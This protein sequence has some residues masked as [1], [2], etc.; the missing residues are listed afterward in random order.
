MN[1]RDVR[2]ESRDLPIH[3]LI[4]PELA[5]RSEIDEEELHRLAADIGR[6]GIL[7]PLIVFPVGERFEIVAGHR[8]YLAATIAGLAILPCR[9]YP[10][11]NVALEGVK[12][13]ENSLRVD[14]SPTAEA[15][16]FS[17]LLERDCGGDVDK[18]CEQLGEK[19]ARVENRLNLLKLHPEVFSALDKGEIGIGIAE[20]LGKC[21]NEQYL[22]MLLRQAIVGG[23]NRSTVR[24]WVQEWKQNEASYESGLA[25]AAASAPT[26]PT[27]EANYF[28]CIVC[29]ESDRVFAMRPVNVHV[30]CKIAILD[31]LLA[32]ARG[33]N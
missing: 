9:I 16:W 23:A 14:V 29:G 26:T 19:R 3:L 24:G 13:A 6:R 10:E 22:R 21:G 31:K 32:A 25:A 4:E 15:A 18:L 28:T 30:E 8:R 17:Q 33:G 5:S 2:V 7:L 27:P 11:K 1:L 20:E 12:Y